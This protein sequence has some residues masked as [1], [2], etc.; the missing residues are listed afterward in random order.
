MEKPPSK[1]NADVAV[2]LT[3]LYN[4]SQTFGVCHG[5]A[6]RARLGYQVASVAAALAW[7]PHEVKAGKLPGLAGFLLFAT[8]EIETSLWPQARLPG[9]HRS[10]G[11]QAVNVVA[12]REVGRD[13]GLDRGANESDFHMTGVNWGV[14][15]PEPT[16]VADP[17]SRGDCAS[18][19][20]KALAIDGTGNVQ[21]G[22]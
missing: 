1:S 8:L 13:G 14:T 5:Y 3:L 4:D 20:D 6:G 22:H 11:L 21:S 19:T 12:D 18:P 17:S 10:E 2:F 16:L 9:P 7:R 15:L